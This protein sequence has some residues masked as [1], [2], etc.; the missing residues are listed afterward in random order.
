MRLRVLLFIGV[1][2]ACSAP[3]PARVTDAT[4][5]P[6]VT[7]QAEVTSPPSTI[8]PTSPTSPPPPK[9]V[10]LDLRA[11]AADP[12]GPPA[13]VHRVSY[14]QGAT[15]LGIIFSEGP[16]FGPGCIAFAESSIAVADPAND[17]VLVV[18]PDGDSYAFDV[19]GEVGSL[20]RMRAAGSDL[21]VSG[22]VVDAES[23][24]QQATVAVFDISGEPI[25]TSITPY[26]FPG[27]MWSGDGHRP[28]GAVW[29]EMI[30]EVDTQFVYE[31]VMHLAPSVAVDEFHLADGAVAEVVGAGLDTE[32]RIAGSSELIVTVPG[33]AEDLVVDGETLYLAGFYPADPEAEE[34]VDVFFAA[35][36]VAGELVR[37]LETEPS[38][39][40]PAQRLCESQMAISPQGDLAVMDLLESGVELRVYP[41]LLRP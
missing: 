4:S 5:P 17:R 41:G 14:G 18:I 28:G 9:V 25:D 20:D 38:W 33:F 11:V 22:F 19:A 36:L 40:G 35:T 6:S 8:A 24:T 32:I 30:A 31:R 37:Y 39:E 3:E 26:K 23:R 7:T 1:V 34:T 29:M 12:L 13:V 27:Q 16:A 21:V 10:E 2:S 15:D